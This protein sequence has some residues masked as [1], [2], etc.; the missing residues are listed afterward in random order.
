MHIDGWTLLLQAINLAVLLV[1]LRWL[2]YKPLMAVIDQRQQRVNEALAAAQRER[3]QAEQERQAL[4]TQRAQTSASRDA[5]LQAPVQ[6]P[7]PSARPC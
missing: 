6:A 4:A 7:R 2:L 1:L 5:W 3:E